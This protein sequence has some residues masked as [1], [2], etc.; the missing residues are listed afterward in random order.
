MGNVE[1]TPEFMKEYEHNTGKLLLKAI[2][3][4]CKQQVENAVDFARKQLATP[5]MKLSHDEDYA[6]MTQK[7]TA[8]LTRKYDVGDGMLWKKTPV[9]LAM[10]V[11]AHETVEYLKETI[12]KLSQTKEQRHINT[13]RAPAIQ[14]AVGNIDQDR[15]AL[16]KSRLQALRKKEAP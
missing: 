16:A 6:I 7:M 14:A 15:V 2:R 5:N 11:E 3:N 10:A 8:Y 4:D 13:D 1:M 12:L 9:E